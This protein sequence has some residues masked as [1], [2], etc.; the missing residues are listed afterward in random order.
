[1]LKGKMCK[2]CAH[3]YANEKMI[4]VETNPNPEQQLKENTACGT[5]S[6]YQI[7][8]IIQVKF[9]MWNTIKE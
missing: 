4:P 6:S 5:I 8:V 7:S 1:V 3:M 9:T 2:Y